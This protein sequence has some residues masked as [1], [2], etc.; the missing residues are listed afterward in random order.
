M[1]ILGGSSTVSELCNCRTYKMISRQSIGQFFTTYSLL[2]YFT[3][4]VDVVTLFLQVY[5]ESIVSLKVHLFLCRTEQLHLLAVFLVYVHC[6][7]VNDQMSRPLRREHSSEIRLDVHASKVRFASSRVSVLNNSFEEWK[8][9][10]NLIHKL[11]F[12]GNHNFC[13]CYSL[14]LSIVMFGCEKEGGEETWENRRDKWQI[15]VWILQSA[16]IHDLTSFSFGVLSFHA[17]EWDLWLRESSSLGVGDETSST[18]EY[19]I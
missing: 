4:S 7:S 2:I 19:L 18:I 16:Q 3:K 15:V 13:S 14:H 12:R 8:D 1:K 5:E 6:I 17:F 9:I 10:I 11:S